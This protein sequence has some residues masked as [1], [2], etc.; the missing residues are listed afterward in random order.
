MLEFGVGT[1]TSRT[2]LRLMPNGKLCRME[3]DSPLADIVR[4]YAQRWLV[5]QEIAEQ[6]AFFH[7]NQLGSSIVIKVDFDLT[8]TLLAHNLY[9]VLATKL[10]GFE[11]CTVGTIHRNFLANEATVVIQN[12][13]I[14]V[15]LKKKS[16][17]PL[18]YKTPWMKNMTKL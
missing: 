7:L 12:R 5:E 18:L 2:S 1:K 13:V 14:E 11:H 17:L 16:H 4:K 3:K 8:M 10:T 9:R 15:A 6:I